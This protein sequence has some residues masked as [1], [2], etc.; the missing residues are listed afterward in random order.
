MKKKIK[1]IITILSL[2]VALSLGLSVAVSASAANTEQFTRAPGGVMDI[3]SGVWNKMPEYDCDY[4]LSGQNINGTTAGYKLMWDSQKIYF[5]FKAHDITPNDKDK[6]EI[7][8]KYKE[9]NWG[10]I[11]ATFA[12]WV[13][14]GQFGNRTGDSGYEFIDSAGC[15]K[16]NPSQDREIYFAVTLR[17]RTC[18]KAGEA[19]TINMNYYD[20]A[21]ADDADNAA[22]CRLQSGT[23][24]SGDACFLVPFAYYADET[25]VE[26]PDL[27]LY[28]NI[29]YPDKAA[30]NSVAEKINAIGAVTIDKESK[31]AEARS[32]YD[33]LTSAQKEYISA[34]TLKKLTDAES[35]LA[36]LKNP[37][38]PN[39]GDGDNENPD[40]NNP[41]DNKNPSGSGKKKK[42]G[43]GGSASASG[44]PLALG[45][46]LISGIILRSG[47]KKTRLD[48]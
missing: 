47:K 23:L 21:H 13:G 10:Y 19:L 6:I 37:V 14:I 44:L 40:G 33:A 17:D 9:E 42:C 43:C 34:E 2:A 29:L 7:S 20:Y 1:L 22:I 30:A 26:N 31:I 5:G 28:D 25:Y 45:A 38:N 12:P 8:I 32:A 36:A 39:P 18:L 46:L 27:S 3:K 15:D 35:E 11:F 16:N 48:K 41:D 24:R 4:L